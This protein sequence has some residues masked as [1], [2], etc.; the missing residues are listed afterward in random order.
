MNNILD[1]S[2]S[3]LKQWL[4]ENNIEEYRGKQIFKFLYSGIS[5]FNLYNNIPKA[6]INKLSE[7]FYADIPKIV[8]IYE[9]KNKSTKKLLLSFKDNNIIETVLMKYEYG[10]SICVSTQI[11]CRMGC[12]FCA[13]GLDGLVRNLTSGEIMAQVIA[14]N[15]VLND[16]VSNIVLMGSGEPLDNYDNVLKFIEN[17]SKKETLNIG[18]RHIT[19]STC[20]IVPNIIKLADKKMQLTLAISLHA[21]ND[22]KRKEL[23]PI[24]NKY[25]VKEIIEACRYYID[26]TNK[27]ITFEYAL[28][29]DKNDSIPDAEGLSDLLSGMLCHV[30]LIPV[31]YVS[32][33]NL[34]K[35][36]KDSIIKFCEVLK[37]NNI[38]YTIRREMGEDINA[39][40][41]QLR[42]GY[43]EEKGENNG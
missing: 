39:A 36:N 9:S 22:D 8:K 40:C 43:L 5:D 12:S 28:V 35:S 13:S 32:E 4:K 7:N 10:Y 11:G 26:K 19:L 30:N 34:S 31:N 42:R 33:K 23:M 16:R 18:A 24:A 6:L 21:F 14:G 20:G 3:E 2:L 41:G 1:Y 15:K 17:V 27:R 25:A 29:N 38:N 37:M